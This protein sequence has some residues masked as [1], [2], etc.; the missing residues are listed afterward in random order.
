V[1]GREGICIGLLL[2]RY[3]RVFS[4][5]KGEV[6][7]QNCYGNRGEHKEERK[8]QG[9]VEKAPEITATAWHYEGMG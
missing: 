5:E 2:K 3:G 1:Q 6:K 7:A 9:N 8:A 4:R